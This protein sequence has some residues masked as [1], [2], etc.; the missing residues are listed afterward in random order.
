MESFAAADPQAL[1]NT[2]SIILG[3]TIL[4]VSICIGYSYYRR[5]TFFKQMGE[6]Q[7]SFSAVRPPAV[8]P[9]AGYFL[10]SN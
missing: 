5:D 8:A 10:L 2:N 1:L 3:I 4:F 7:D 9:A 6:W